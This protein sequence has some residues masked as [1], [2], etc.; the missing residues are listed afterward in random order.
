MALNSK[1]SRK[2]NN[3][4]ATVRPIVKPEVNFSLIPKKLQ[5]KVHL[6]Q[7]TRNSNE[8][9]KIA[10]SMLPQRRKSSL[11]FSRENIFHLFKYYRFKRDNQSHYLSK[12]CMKTILRNQD[13]HRDSER[14]ERTGQ[15]YRPKGVS[16]NINLQALQV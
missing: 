4:L 2:L 7:R 5:P 16:L 8:S 13:E 12:F 1:S 3:K 10:A 14:F 6:L 11:A 9:F 15:N